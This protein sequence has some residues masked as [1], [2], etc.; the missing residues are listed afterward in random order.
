M[1]NEA[2]RPIVFGG[3]E[4]SSIRR[5][6]GDDIEERERDAC[7]GWAESDLEH[8]AH[9]RPTTWI[10][11]EPDLFVAHT[12]WLSDQRFHD[13]QPDSVTAARKHA[14]DKHGLQ[15]H[16]PHRWMS[17]LTEEVGEAAKE[18][19]DLNE[20]VDRNGTSHVGTSAFVRRL[21][22]ELAQVASMAIHFIADLEGYAVTFDNEHPE[23]PEVERG[24]LD[25]KRWWV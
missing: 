4:L 14:I 6:E 19:N 17:I 9:G 2:Q 1:T 15:H 23:F 13:K 21:K 24:P 3:A 7:R 10:E 8:A 11:R 16:D 18:I 5:T 20:Y 22:D 25:P 12:Y